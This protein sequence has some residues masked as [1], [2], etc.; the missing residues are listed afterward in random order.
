[1]KKIGMIFGASLLLASFT[2]LSA[3]SGKS[4]AKSNQS[5]ERDLHFTP[6]IGYSFIN[7][8]TLNAYLADE[9]DRLNVKSQYKFSGGMNFGLRGEYTFLEVASVGLRL[10][11]FSSSTTY[12]TVEKNNQKANIRSTLTAV[13]VYLT[14]GYKYQ[15]ST[16]W[17]VGPTVGIGFPLS[18]KYT[19]EVTSSNIPTLKNGE[20]SYSDSPLTWIAGGF[21]QYQLTDSIAIRGDLEYRYLVSSQ[22]RLDEKY[23][24]EKAGRLFENKDKENI[25]VD[26]SS[27]TTSLGVTLSI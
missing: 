12:A 3:E 26:L 11:Y 25:K 7:P 13:P 24:D 21:T 1:M 10:D 18:F 27:F 2:T 9:A 19:T 16:N 4:T 22:L 5:Q 20:P 23:M 14:A 6:T 8:K 17:S 15:A